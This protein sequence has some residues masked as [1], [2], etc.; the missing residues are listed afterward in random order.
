MIVAYD[1][2]TTGPL[3]TWM[4]YR[5]TFLLTT[6]RSLAVFISPNIFQAIGMQCE[7]VNVTSL[8]NIG[9]WAF[10]KCFPRSTGDDVVRT[11][12]RNSEWQSPW[13]IAKGKMFK[14]HRNCPQASHVSMRREKRDISLSSPPSSVNHWQKVHLKCNEQRANGKIRNSHFAH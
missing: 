8:K 12:D 11:S 7:E 13:L 10:T 6:L 9:F 1:V 3:S 2:S 14:I 4:A 5:V